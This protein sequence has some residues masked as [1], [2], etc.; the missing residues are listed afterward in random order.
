M[1]ETLG[2]LQMMIESL[3]KK[4]AVLSKIIDK[5]EAQAACIAEE[6]YDGVNWEQFNVLIAEKDTLIEKVNELDSGF[7]S[8]YD[9]I[10]DELTANK[11][12]YKQEIAEMQSLITTLTDKGTKIMTMEERNRAK[13]E[14]VLMGAKKEIKQSRKSM[15]VVSSYYKSMSNPGGDS[16]GYFDKT[17]K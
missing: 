15:Q 16:S 13:L 3:R 7:Q 1:N 9:R 14:R 2:Y 12:Q 10:K 6:G 4:D 8:L 11:E 17:S 5:N